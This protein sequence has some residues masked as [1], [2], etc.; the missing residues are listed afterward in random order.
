MS[1]RD[2]HIIFKLPD[3]SLC[4]FHIRGHS[5]NLYLT[6]GHILALSEELNIRI[7]DIPLNMSP[8]FRRVEKRPFHI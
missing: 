5:N 7:S 6:A 8:F 3:K 4:P 1:D 2:H